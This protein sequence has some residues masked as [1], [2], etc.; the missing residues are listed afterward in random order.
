MRVL[1]VDDEA[2]ARRK[3]E[4]FLAEHADVELVGVA[5]GAAEGALRIRRDRPDLV[6]L[7]VQM[8]GMDGFALVESLSADED[9]PKFVFV[10]AH[11]RYAVRAFDVCALDYLLKPFDRERFD[12]ALQ[13]ARESLCERTD[14]AAQ[15]ATLLGTLGRPNAFADR[16]LVSAEDRSVFVSSDD[17]VRVEAS[18]NVVILHCRARSFSL[19][20]T[21]DAFERR[22]DPRV[23]VRLSRSHIV[24]LD[25][26][27][28]LQPWFHGEFRVKLADG[29]MLT[30]S[31]RY[32]EKR[33]DL[34]A[35][36]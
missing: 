15:L 28:E 26:I 12:R 3:V 30:W 9:L 1:V 21:M 25:A 35:R 10:T 14:T 34:R 32:A 36:P 20:T 5:A 6:F 31:R 27:D 11:D 7:D 16:F 8:P 23:F 2:P 18:R 22:L 4:R 33:P 29:S 24:R 13:R 17:L 19:R